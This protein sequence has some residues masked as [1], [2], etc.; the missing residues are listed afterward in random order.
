MKRIIL[1]HGW[2]ANSHANWLPWLKSELQK[3]GH[4]VVV[5]DM[6]DTDSPLPEK[7]VNY[8]AKIIGTPDQ[9]TYLIGHSMGCQTILKYLETT[10]TPI[11]GALF[12]AGW[13]YLE[14]IED[15]DE[16]KFADLWTNVHIDIHKIKKVLPKSTLIISDNDDWGAVEKNKK[17]FSEFV[18]KE[19]VLHNK[20]HITNLQHQEILSEAVHLLE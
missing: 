5:P 3:R 13:F 18:T 15:E 4:E 1:I 11:G 14:N 17:K 16:R 2:S 8:L 12:V 9:D 7:W 20:G 19:V 6:P 10:P